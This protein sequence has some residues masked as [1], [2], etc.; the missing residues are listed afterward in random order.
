ML[1]PVSKVTD[2]ARVA[3]ESRPA[4][5]D[6]HNGLVQTNREEDGAVL[7]PFFGKRC[8][9][10]LFDPFTGN[11]VLREHQQQ[12]IVE[13]NRFEITT[14]LQFSFRYVILLA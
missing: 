7:F 4:A 12:F 3:N 11:R 5:L 14:G 9:H 8:F 2:V 13:V 10:F 1:F 6:F